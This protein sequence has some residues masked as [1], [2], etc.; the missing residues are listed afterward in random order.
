MPEFRRVQMVVLKTE[1]EAQDIKRRIETG[2]M[3]MYEGAQRHSI[4][5]DAK[6]TSVILAGYSR[7]AY[8]CRSLKKRCSL[9]VLTRNKVSGTFY[10]LYFSGRPRVRIVDSRP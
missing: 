2:E 6:K 5:P 4:V 3:N 7:A 1:E 9:S 10:L 8:L